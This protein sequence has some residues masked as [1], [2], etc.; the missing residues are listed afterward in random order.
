MK[1]SA[2][3]LL[4]SLFLVTGC[5]IKQVNNN[6]LGNVVDTILG[7]RNSL[8][9][10][11]SSGYKFYLPRGVRLLDD[12]SYN[13]RLESDG[14]KYYLYVDVVS[15][16]FKK[17]SKYTEND[18]AYFSKKLDYNKKQG[19]LEITKIDNLYFV[20]M[21]YNYSK[22]EVFVPKKDLF[23]TVV[24]ASYILNS[25]K[26]NDKIIKTLFDE[27]KLDYNEEKFELFK[28]KRKEGNFLD[29]VKEYDQYEQDIDEDLIA[30][31]DDN[32]TNNQT[33]GSNSN[34]TNSNTTTDNTL[35]NSL[36]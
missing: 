28:P 29:Y 20:E 12:T 5:S 34:D 33:D 6:D 24:N 3:L 36:E 16:Y 17:N 10:Q 25:M 31:S 1:R 19:Y 14:N 15:Y 26:F 32:T 11:V 7:T 35:D 21:M 4:L 22:I 27:N 13:E 8:Y 30:P 9:N 18:E 23:Q 2:I